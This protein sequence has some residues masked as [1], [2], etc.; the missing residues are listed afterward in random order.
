MAASTYTGTGTTQS[1]TNGGNNTTSTTF[2]PD[3]VW[4]KSRSNAYDNGLEDAV[5]QAM[6]RA[7]Q[8]NLDNVKLAAADLAEMELQFTKL[9]LAKQGA[10]T[11]GERKIVRAVP[12]TVSSSPGVLKTRVEL[13]RERAKFD[14]AE[15]D[16]FNE[17]KKNNP[18]ASYIDW[19]NSRGYRELLNDFSEKSDKIYE[20]MLSR[21]AATPVPTARPRG[22]PSTWKLMRD[23]EG[24]R[25]WVDP[26][27]PRNYK[28]VQ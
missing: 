16:G 21:N 13:L 27:N 3:L 11:E 26:K 6:P 18:T 14:R 1:I 10:V 12:G 5:R 24:N 7:T 25:A 17:F 8:R 9:Y 20:D 23:A 28:E 2:Q 19:Q 4:A 22:V 15:I